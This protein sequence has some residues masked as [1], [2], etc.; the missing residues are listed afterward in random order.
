MITELL[1]GLGSG[2]TCYALGALTTRRR[3][4]KPVPPMCPC[5]H[6]ISAHD[7]NDG[8][9]IGQIRREYYNRYGDRNGYEYV[10]CTCRRY[11]GPALISAFTYQQL[12]TQP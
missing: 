10:R 6:L 8:P 7:N 11:I 12:T 2:L 1:S 9:C 3:H 5:T 4:R